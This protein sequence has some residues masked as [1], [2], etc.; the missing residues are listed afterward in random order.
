MPMGSYPAILEKEGD[1]Y[2]KGWLH[3]D[4]FITR[5]DAAHGP[6]M[7]GRSVRLASVMGSVRLGG[8]EAAL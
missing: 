8:V 1:S 3:G 6:A 2:V 4:V 7:D 5:F